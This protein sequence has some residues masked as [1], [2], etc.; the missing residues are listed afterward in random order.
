MVDEVDLATK[1]LEQAI[2]R[3]TM[4]FY[5]NIEQRKDF[6]GTVICK[7]CAEEIPPERAAIKGVTRCMHCQEQLERD[8]VKR[9]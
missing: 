4:K 1:E 5:E 9:K 2:E 3:A 6:T 8:T 7:D